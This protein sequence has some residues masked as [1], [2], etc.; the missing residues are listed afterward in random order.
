MFRQS[1]GDSSETSQE[2]KNNSTLQFLNTGRNSTLN[3]STISTQF[4]DMVNHSNGTT[5][6]QLVALPQQHSGYIQQQPPHNNLTTIV[7]KNEQI[8]TMIIEPQSASSSSTMTSFGQNYNFI[9]G[10]DTPTSQPKMYRLINY[11]SNSEIPAQQF[12]RNATTSS[13]QL[14]TDQQQLQQTSSR[15]RMAF[16]QTQQQYQHS[17]LQQNDNRSPQLLLPEQGKSTRRKLRHF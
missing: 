11:A 12:R 7:S 2:I 17:K 10:N 15:K 16:H 1:C 3:N 6:Y 14:L 13:P 9:S 5:S 8:M 4:S